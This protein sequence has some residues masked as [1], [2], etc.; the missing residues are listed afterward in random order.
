[1]MAL[2]N[3]SD[4][5]KLE[6]KLAR[7]LVRSIKRGH[8][9]IYR[10]ALRDLPDAKPGTPAL[11]LD[12]R[13]SRAIARGF[14]TPKSA[15]AFRVC[16]T[17][18]EEELTDE[19]AAEQMKRAVS[20]RQELYVDSTQETTGFRL[21]NGEGDGLP[22]LVCDVYS[23]H[24]VLRFDGPAARNFWH[25][26]GIA[27]WL[28]AETNV[29]HVYER[30]RSGGARE[31]RKLAGRF[32]DCPV[33]FLEHGIQLTADVVDGQKTGFYLDQ[34]ENRYRI[35]RYS[36]DRRVL[37]LYGYTGGF[38]VSA[39]LSGARQVTIVDQADPALQTAQKH[40]QMND[41]PPERFTA[42]R[43]EVFPFLEQAIQKGSLWDLVIID[44]PSF[45]PSEERVKNASQAYRRLIASGI[46]VTDSNGYIAASSC[47]SHIRQD[48]F[49]DLCQQALSDSRRKG[50]IHGIYGLPPDHPTPLIM[51]ELRY[52]KFIILRL[53]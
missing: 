45:A 44:P 32:P 13:S 52:L 24:A 26:E 25:P 11:L 4:S 22:G 17:N 30:I 7:N 12:H 34:R 49:L 39:G 33:A 27:Q 20:L 47:S 2:I 37:D 6:L 28:I 15:I 36:K 21:F 51:S 35:R 5:P 31:G 46:R 16:T 53:D 18:P 48:V 19:W 40:W 42:I 14:Y 1:M 23:D 41:L 43:M 38:S 9:W 50:T 10:E 29:K 8:A 3:S